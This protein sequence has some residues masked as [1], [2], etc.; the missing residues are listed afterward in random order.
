MCRTARERTI[1][2]CPDDPSIKPSQDS[3]KANDM[4]PGLSSVEGQVAWIRHQQLVKEGLHEQFMA[5]HLPVPASAHSPRSV[6]RDRWTALLV[7]AWRSLHDVLFGATKG[8]GH[9]TAQ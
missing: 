7:G 8:A 5:T 6:I 1:S 3:R 4:L 9:I 2:A